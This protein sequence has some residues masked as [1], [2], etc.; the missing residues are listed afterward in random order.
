MNRRRAL[1]VAL[2]A[3]LATSGCSALDVLGGGEPAP[4]SED[5]AAQFAELETLRATQVSTIR[6]DG[7]TNHTRSVV[8]IDFGDPRRQYQRVLAPPERAGTRIVANETA[9]TIY[10]PQENTVT[11]IPRNERATYDRGEY[12]ARIVAAARGN[13]TVEKSAGV[14]P[15]PVVPAT[16]TPHAVAR[17]LQGYTVEYLGTASVSG[18]HAYKF[19]MAASSEAALAVNRTLWLDA[20]FYYPLKVHQTLTLGND[21]YEITKRLTNVTFN[22]PLPADAFALDPP[23]NATVETLNVSAQR[24]DSLSALREATAVPV[25]DPELPEGYEFAGAQLY[26]R[27]A[28]QVSL[29][30]ESA[31]G[32]IT[33][34]KATGLGNASRGQ[35]LGE[36]VTVA[37][38]DGRYL[39]AG[40]SSMVAVTCG[41]AQY[42]VVATSLEKQALLDV[43]ASVVCE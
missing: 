22:E 7:T 36:N 9:A 29:R 43:A 4:P 33:V 30:Y 23:A 3:L 16:S 25:P 2:A 32:R 42:T 27:N 34:S 6:H 19:R 28:T 11:R 35:Q 37:G 5:V 38:H 15:L 24:F 20:E 8:R 13:E 18:R 21:T 14:S 39:V 26:D 40:P 12:F 1:A 41:D 17:E 31:D 10:D